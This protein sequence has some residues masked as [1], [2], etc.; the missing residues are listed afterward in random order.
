[1]NLQPLLQDCEKAGIRLTLQGAVVDIVGDSVPPE[2]IVAGIKRAAPYLAAHLAGYR[3]EAWMCVRGHVS[4]GPTA[5]W[6]AKCNTCG[7]LRQGST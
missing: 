6:W 2:A 4:L 5:S 3:G 7:V 1:M